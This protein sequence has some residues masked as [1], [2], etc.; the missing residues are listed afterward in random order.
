VT[1]RS[2]S[3]KRDGLACLAL[4][5]VNA[6]LCGPLFGIAYLDDFQS[7]EGTFITFARFLSAHWPH[8][9][10][11]PWFN[12]G[13][14]FENTYLPL[15]SF[16]TAAIAAAAHCSPAHALHILAALAYSLAPVFLYLF[17]ARLSGRR[18]ASL[19]A[20]LLW[21]L[22]SPSI[23]I[24]RIL[25]D[26]GTPWGLRRLQ[27][28]VF[29]GETPHNLALCLL[30]AALLLLARYLER[31]TPR[32]FAL[33]ALAGAAVMASNAFGIVTLAISSVLLWAAL[34]PLTWKQL[35]G[36]SGILLA[37][38]LT[39]CR[40][41]PP[42]LMG[43]IRTNS[44]LVGGDYRF[45]LRSAGIAAGFLMCLVL[46]W[47]ATRRLWDPMLR[48]AIWFSAVFG[49]ITVLSFLNLTFLPQP[50]RYHIEMG[51]GLCLV[52]AF[53]AAH[54]SD[55]LP[56]QGLVVL[57]VAGL[58]AAGWLFA[59]DYRYARR[60]IHPAEITRS[61]PYREASWVAAHLPGQRIFAA[62]EDQWWFNLFADNPQLSAG[63]EPSAPNYVQR[64]AVYTI[65]SG[66]NA[67][68]QDA[69]ISILWLRALGC[70][71]ITVAGPASKDHYHG[72][73]HP[74]KFEGRL[75]LVWRED[76]DSIYQVPLRSVSLA[77]VIPRTAVV[78]RRP[79]HGLDVDQV[80]RY[81]AA[82]EDPAIPP[83]PLTWE[84]PDHGRILATIPSGD[85]ISVQV[86][87][88]RGW[89]ARVG[90]RRVPVHADQLG[91]M[92]VEPQCSGDCMV[93]LE[94]T[95]GAERAICL[96]VSLMVFGGLLAALWL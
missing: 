48:F 45:T 23:L 68:A 75:P 14:P 91:L 27:N 17:A 30:P 82:L 92:I 78:T 38:Y 33:A 93:D 87:C 61:A 51:A 89:Q 79:I 65:L 83:A 39:I 62:G 72:F 73:V 20:A 56:R 81:V 69:D 60:L 19:A 71:A 18:A 6:L 58:L 12:A 36:I 50:G 67:G 70:G 55:R 53:A 76:G 80:R 49:G 42:S 47:L 95:G 34:P 57:G 24:P 21:S 54:A 5:A 84:N 43:L 28:I 88:D 40:F 63:H 41:L 96:V 8:V 74:G 16:A 2:S 64:M 3:A 86:T 46:L 11:F 4:F 35:A 90:G 9:R 15:T 94:F 25:E 31:M 52:A 59:K 7:N 32:R 37:A 22:F 26:L 29:Y 1:E 13:M 85:V 77:H 10:W 44:Q 66:K